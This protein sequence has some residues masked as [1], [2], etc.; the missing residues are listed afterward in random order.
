M[1]KTVKTLMTTMA[2]AGFA[3]AGLLPQVAVARQ[4][5]PGAQPAAAAAVGEVKT[6]SATVLGVDKKTRTVTLK[7]ETGNVM[8]V[9]VPDEVVAFDQVKKGDKIKMAYT[10]AVALDIYPPGEARPEAKDTESSYRT[11]GSAPSRVISRTQTMAGEIISV[12]PKKNKVKVKGP[13][14]KAREISVTDPDVQARLKDL[15]P[16]QVVEVRFKEAMAVTLEP[17][18]K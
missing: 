3:I 13:E 12:D 8:T 16:G 4:A 9:A 18:S 5:E 14:G 17:A 11:G 6:A 15:K 2:G 1:R 10:E 7:G